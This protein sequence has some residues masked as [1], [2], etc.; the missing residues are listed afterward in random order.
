MKDQAKV[1]L[2]SPDFPNPVVSA[3]FTCSRHKAEHVKGQAFKIRNIAFPLCPID[4]ESVSI[5]GGP[6]NRRWSWDVDRRHP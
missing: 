4:E 5:F 2:V 3:D 1:S 6:I